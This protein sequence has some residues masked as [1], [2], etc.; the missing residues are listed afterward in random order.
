M[1][2]TWTIGDLAQEFGVTLRA[3]RFYE[4]CGLLQPVREGRA[5]IY[6]AR[7]RARLKLILRGKRLGFS[8]AEI[9]E[10]L[11]LYA[12]GDAQIEQLRVTLDRSRER[13]AAMERQRQDLDQAIAEL[14]EGCRQMEAALARGDLARIKPSCA[15]PARAKA[16]PKQD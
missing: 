10:M 8:L 7:D 16:D 14:T 1:S 2:Q 4:D 15:L 6:H 11:D 13:L 3:I 12:P 5:R 9:Q